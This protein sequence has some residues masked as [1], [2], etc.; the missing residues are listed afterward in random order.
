M[1]GFVVGDGVDADVDV[2]DLSYAGC[3]LLP[4]QPLPEGVKVELVIKRKGRIEA[5]VRWSNGQAT[6]LM[7]LQ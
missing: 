1:T 2:A 7:F 6:G 4:S 3:K 5:E